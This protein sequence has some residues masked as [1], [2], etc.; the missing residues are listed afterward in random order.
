MNYVRF[1]NKR[2]M[3]ILGALFIIN[4][5]LF[6]LPFVPG[7]I[8]SISKHAAVQDIPDVKA[9]YSADDVYQFLTAIGKEGRSAYQLMH[10]TID[11]TFPLV[12]GLLF[13]SIITYQVNRL[14]FEQKHL[15]LI[16][17][18]AAAFDFF[19]NGTHLYINGTYPA[20]QLRA[21][22]IAELF[23]LLKFSFIAASLMTI[24]ILGIKIIKVKPKKSK[25][26]QSGLE[27]EDK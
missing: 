14:E 3:L 9:I 19:E 23:S 4:M 1:V 12:Y 13:F 22:A 8:P 6:Y 10:L 15:A 24:I 17:F 5:V 25:I 16:A 11:F 20:Y 27:K 2:R 18:V 21:T 26:N 7:S